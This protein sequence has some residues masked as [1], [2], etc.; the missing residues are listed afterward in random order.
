[1]PRGTHALT[2][3]GGKKEGRCRLVQAAGRETKAALSPPAG[4]VIVFPLRRPSKIRR[5]QN[6]ARAQGFASPRKTGAP[7]RSALRSGRCRTRDGRLRREHDD[8]SAGIT[9]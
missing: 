4:I 8:D 5:C 9:Y 3:L 6:G 1:M 7:L 2:G